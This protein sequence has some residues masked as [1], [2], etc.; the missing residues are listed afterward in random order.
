M[1]DLKFFLYSAGMGICLL[2]YVSETFATNAKVN[3]LH[4]DVREIRADVKELLKRD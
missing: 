2:A 3:D 4:Q 1:N